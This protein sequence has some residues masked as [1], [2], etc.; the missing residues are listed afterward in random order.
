LVIVVDS[1]SFQ[2]PIA[3]LPISGHDQGRDEEAEG[4]AQLVAEDAE[5]GGERDLRGREPE[6]GEA[7]GHAERE[8]LGDGAHGL[9]EHGEREEVGREGEAFEEGAEGC[10]EAAEDDGELE[11]AAVQQEHGREDE[12]NVAEHVD[13]GEPVDGVVLRGRS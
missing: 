5:R 11:A 7:G 6:G 12:R 3:Q 13:H 4:G 9:G 2:L 10:E 1:I 8:G